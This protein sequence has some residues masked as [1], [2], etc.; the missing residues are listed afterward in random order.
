MTVI[1]DPRGTNGT[2]PSYAG[3]RQDSTA[4]ASAACAVGDL[5]AV[6]M[7]VD[8]DIRVA[9]FDTDTHDPAS[10]AAVALE[11]SEAADSVIQI[12]VGG[13]VLVNIGAGAVAVAE[14]VIA[15][16]DA[17]VAD[18][19]AADATTVAGDVHGVFLSDEVGTTNKAWAWIS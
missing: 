18:G 11:T 15:T 17:G 12:A 9:P 6:T 4:I 14:L 13:P 2:D 16:A 10:K 5:L 3:M 19:V 1:S 7:A 8:G